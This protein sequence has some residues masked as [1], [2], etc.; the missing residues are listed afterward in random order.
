MYL[1][2]LQLHIFTS[3]K[4]NWNCHVIGQQIRLWRH[5]LLD[6]SL[7]SLLSMSPSWLLASQRTVT[8]WGLKKVTWLRTWLVLRVSVTLVWMLSSSGSAVSCCHKAVWLLH[9]QVGRIDA[10]VA[11]NGQPPGVRYT[12]LHQC[13]R[14][15]LEHAVAA[16]PLYDGGRDPLSYT[17]HQVLLPGEG[18]VNQVFNLSGN[19]RYRRKYLPLP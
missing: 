15:S 5:L 16:V 1:I 17:R 11:V 9:L 13:W 18:M 8:C 2:S 14:H 7:M 4:R 19:Y 12:T 10:D 3:Q 6:T